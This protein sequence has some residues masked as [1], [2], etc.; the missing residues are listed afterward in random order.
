LRSNCASLVGLAIGPR[1]PPASQPIRR[2]QPEN[3]C[4]RERSP[5]RDNLTEPV[6]ERRAQGGQDALPEG[7]LD[8]FRLLTELVKQGDRGPKKG[9][10]IVVPADGAA[11]HGNTQ[12]GVCEQRLLARAPGFVHGVDEG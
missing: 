6:P 12:H 2:S 10:G 7:C 8:A 1:N 5:G 9:G 11:H 4:E 3:F